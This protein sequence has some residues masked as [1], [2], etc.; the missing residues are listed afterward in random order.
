MGMQEDLRRLFAEEMAAKFLA[1][2]DAEGRVNLSVVIS[3]QPFPEA[4]AELVFADMMMRR[5][6]GNLQQDPRATALVVD[7]SLRTAVVK[8]TF[9]G[10][11]TSGPYKEFVDSSPFL[12]YNAYSGSRA[13]GVLQ[14]VEALPV[15]SISLPSV[16]LDKTRVSLARLPR[17]RGRGELPP[18]VSR[19]FSA[20]TS[21]KA[22]AVPGKDGH[23]LVLPVMALSYRKGGGMLMRPAAYE[24]A[25]GEAELPAPG[26]LSLLTMDAKSYKVGG[27]VERRGSDLVLFLDSAWSG[28]PPLV[29]EE[30]EL[31]S[32]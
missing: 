30:I 12:R 7:R 29:G 17:G 6:R 22:L 24:E 9:S 13:A 3:L 2:R 25:L 19:R 15:S 31:I 27:R 32:S 16:L 18:L 21:M 10:F 23:P 20:L 26:M 4:E 1:S 5:T 8:A 14:V 11:H 28:M